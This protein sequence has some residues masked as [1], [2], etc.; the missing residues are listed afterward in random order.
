MPS[1]KDLPE[2]FPKTLAEWRRWLKRNHAKSQGVWL[3]YYKKASGKQQL[4][5]S[6]AVDEALCWGWIDSLM[7]PIDEQRYRQVYTPRKPT[8]VW[9]ALNKRKIQRM[10]SEGRMQPAGFAC[11]EA[12]KRNGSWEKLDAV[13]ALEMPP[14]LSKALR[15]KKKAIR[16]YESLTPGRKKMILTWLNNAKREETRRT[17]IEKIVTAL[18]EEKMPVG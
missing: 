15:R 16:F 5:Y 4:T 1:L 3:I 2:I 6:E 12:A 18:A 11:I 10:I 13:E 7:N 8:S 14:E 9:S 17:R